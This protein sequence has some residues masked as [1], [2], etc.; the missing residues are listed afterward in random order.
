MAQRKVNIEAKQEIEVSQKPYGEKSFEVRCKKMIGVLSEKFPKHAD[1]ISSV[2]TSMINHDPVK[3]AEALQEGFLKRIERQDVGETK[4]RMADEFAKEIGE[5]LEM[6]R[7]EGFA[8]A[9]KIAA[10][11]ND[12]GIK[13]F[14][15]K[16]WSHTS[17]NKLIHRRRQLGLE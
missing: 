16:S 12:L 11:F 14:Q 17:V 3:V 6:V 2:F 5:K 7:G 4:S 9:R 1:E 8:S 10:R 13:S 15:G